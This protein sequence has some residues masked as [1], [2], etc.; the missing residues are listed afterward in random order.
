MTVGIE[1][2]FPGMKVSRMFIKKGDYI[3][4]HGHPNQH[5]LLFVLEGRCSIKKY[6]FK[7]KEDQ[8]VK[9]QLIDERILMKDDYSV[10]TPKENIH[11][12]IAEEDTS[13]LDIFSP[14]KKEGRL[15][16]YFKILSEDKNNINLVVESIDISKVEMADYL[17]HS[18]KDT[19]IVVD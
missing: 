18:L 5:G 4:L 1:F 9:I 8:C 12:I 6:Q 14:G 2:Y 3:P 13:L 11:T 10:I 16:E 19:I 15:S 7:S 17:K